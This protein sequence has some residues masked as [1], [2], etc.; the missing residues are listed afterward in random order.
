MKRL[1]SWRQSLHRLSAN[2]MQQG[3]VVN[4]PQYALLN[5]Q[6]GFAR[7][8]PSTNAICSNA[9][10]ASFHV[11]PLQPGQQMASYSSFTASSNFGGAQQSSGFLKP[12]NESSF[13][14]PSF[15]NYGS[16]SYGLPPGASS[17]LPVVHQST[18]FTSGPTYSSGYA[19][20]LQ[21]KL[22]VSLSPGCGYAVTPQSAFPKPN[23][24]PITDFPR[25]TTGT[26]GIRFDPNPI[27]LVNSVFTDTR[28]QSKSVEEARLEDYKQVENKVSSTPYQPQF[29]PT[30]YPSYASPQQVPSRPKS[31][32]P[33]ATGGF[34]A[35]SGSFNSAP[36]LVSTGLTGILPQVASSSLPSAYAPAGSKSLFTAAPANSQPQ[37]N[38]FLPSS[39]YSSNLQQPSLS[40]P[41]VANSAP[42][43]LV[44]LFQPQPLNTSSFFPA[45]PTALQP[46]LCSQQ[47]PTFIQ[48][49]VPAQPAPM[50][51]GESNSLTEAY[52]DSHGLLW[53]FP[54]SRLDELLSNTKTQHQTEPRSGISL[55]ERASKSQKEISS[56]KPWRERSDRSL[57]LLRKSFTDHCKAAKL[58]ESHMFVKRGTFQSIKYEPLSDK[59]DTPFMIR[60]AEGQTKAERVDAIEL[61]INAYDPVLVNFTTK[62]PKWM[63]VSELA[64]LTGSRLTQVSARKFKLVHKNRELNDDLTLEETRLKSKDQLDLI[65]TDANARQ[66]PR[67]APAEL[68]PRLT[69]AKCCL[70]PSLVELARMTT[71][72]L[73]RVSNFAVYNEHGMIEFEGITDVTLL[74]LDRIVRID[75][76]TVV[77]YPD[78]SEIAKPKVGQGLNKAAKVTL[79]NCKPKNSRSFVGFYDKLQKYCELHECELINYDSETGKWEFRVKHF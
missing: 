51:S 34:Y 14:P 15:S 7:Q 36:P 70:R 53:L 71:L 27:D 68:L 29:N 4:T 41:I 66:E 55:I 3:F 58:S 18:P 44:S 69:Q 40:T 38:L 2:L 47:A 31:F 43:R 79:Y 73:K 59:D 64:E 48:A 50:P 76:K 20:S 62:V 19:S 12:F 72:E 63:L 30:Q 39:N 77:V 52:N 8:I 46:T 10:Q 22:P 26:K 25:P 35:Y 74:D 21:P 45:Q 6:Q 78:D 61:I 49:E 33:A 24:E 11:N 54:H 37:C 9:S 67:L 23:F 5:T 56:L 28:L 60:G 1:R 65:E 57:P 75:A 17:L 16:C 32:A 42:A 13:H